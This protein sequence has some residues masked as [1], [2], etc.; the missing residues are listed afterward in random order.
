MLYLAYSVT[1]AQAG[2]VY[3]GFNP[4]HYSISVSL[5]E[6]NWD[7]VVDTSF[8]APHDVLLGA[9]APLMDGYYEVPGKA[10]VVFTK[11]PAPVAL[12]ATAAAASGP[13]GLRRPSVGS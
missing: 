10:G 13:G 4:H 11:K 2:A 5:P 3:V 1:D 12:T 9:S 6:G 8:P 7:R